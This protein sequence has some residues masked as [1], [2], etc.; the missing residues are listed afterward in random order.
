MK[1]FKL[2]RPGTDDDVLGGPVARGNV[3]LSA[4]GRR[5]DGEKAIDDLMVGEGSLHRYS[6]SGTKPTVYKIVRVEDAPDGGAV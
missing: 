4:Y 3:Y 6:L 5:L 2:V 1:Q